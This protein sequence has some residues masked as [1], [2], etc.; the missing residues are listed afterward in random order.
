MPPEVLAEIF[1]WTLPSPRK[2][3]RHQTL[4]IT[5]SPWVLT[6]VSCRWRITAISTPSLWSLVAIVYQPDRDPWTSNP[7]PMVETQIARAG[8]NLKVHFH[9]CEATDSFP[10]LEV[11]RCLAKHALRWEELSLTVTSA[12]FPLLASLRGRVPL[13]RRLWFQWDTRESQESADSVDCFESAPSLVDQLTRYELDAPRDIHQGILKLAKNL[14]EACV[15]VSFDGNLWPG[16]GGVIELLSLRR[17]NVSDPFALTFLKF[18]LLEEIAM[19]LDH[20][21]ALIHLESSIARSSCPIRK[22]CIQGCSNAPKIA[23]FLQKFNSI[24][25]FAVITAS[26]AASTEAKILMEIL[27]NEET[28]G[29]IVA[30]HLRRLSFG[31]SDNG[32]LD[33]ATYLALVNYRWKA[34][35]CTL[36]S[37]GLCIDSRPSPDVQV[38]S[39]ISALREDGLDFVVLRGVKA[40]IAMDDWLF[41]SQWN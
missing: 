34:N 22:L 18:P 20:G 36:R 28:G 23:G 24:V 5:D 13:L 41:Y 35:S 9:G 16:P 21:N 30:P 17:L 27:H 10:Q 1:S 3:V 6:H 26:F 29:K 15:T 39:G 37:A 2:L 8:H 32:F 11:F 19:Y 14:V 25:E 12:H 4:C 38:L 31:C 40:S 7:L 33:Y